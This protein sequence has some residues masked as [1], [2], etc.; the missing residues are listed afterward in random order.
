MAAV[1]CVHGIAQQIKGE[2]E[3]LSLWVPA[4]RSGV[5]LAA[6]DAV[7]EKVVDDEVRCA[8]YGDLFRPPGRYL[9]GSQARI[10][11][12]SL[13]DFEQELLFLWWE[14]AAATDPRVIG[15]DK[16]TLSRTPRSVKAALRALSNAR[17]LTGLADQMLLGE[18]RQVR[19][20][21]TDPQIRETAISRLTD[22]VGPETRVV[23]AHS[24]GTVVAYEALCANPNWQVRALVTLGSPLG[25]RR[26][27]FDRLVPR[28]KPDG[29]GVLRGD[30]PGGV[31]EW[32][33]VAD[34]GD[35]VALVE[36]LRPLFGRDVVCALVHN[37]AKAHDVRPYLT[38]IETGH[39]I[40]NGLR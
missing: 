12:D 28:P 21:I 7:A 30:W 20:Y 37:D 11:P 25:I 2:D 15:P 34:A 14:R 17:F 27:I 1:V 9:S 40:G 33:N 10:D 38:A 22:L 23:V 36:D 29:P 5:R 19:R 31:K 13:D 18:L 35:I 24:L 26:L 32:T 8:F 3:L 4:L 16:R 39:A 6:G